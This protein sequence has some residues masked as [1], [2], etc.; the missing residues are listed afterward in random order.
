MPSLLESVE[1]GFVFR[2][3]RGFFLVAI[4]LLML[5][6]LGGAAFF[7][8][9][10]LPA[11]P[12]PTAKEIALSEKDVR[13]YIANPTPAPAAQST[14]PSASTEAQDASMFEM[15][16]TSL[17]ELLPAESYPWDEVYSTVGEGADMHMEV[18]ERGITNE[19]KD[20][21]EPYN[22]YSEMLPPLRSLVGML[23]AFEG[24][25]RLQALKA[26][27]KLYREKQTKQKDAEQT[28]MAEYENRQTEKMFASTSGGMV[29]LSAVA[30]MAFTAMFLVLLSVQRNIKKLVEKQ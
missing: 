15:Q 24:K 5:T 26:F 20:L 29:V 6:I 16:M 9:G 27:V 14:A 1:E 30:G 7:I 10:L 21:F 4:V 22:G 8:W 13:D 19:L 25:E 12:P 18:T 11:G 17:R 23:R 28:A 2:V 3:S